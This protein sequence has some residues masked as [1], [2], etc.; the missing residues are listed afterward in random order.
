MFGV[1]LLERQVLGRQDAGL[2]GRGYGAAHQCQRHEAAWLVDIEL[3][4][5][6][7]AF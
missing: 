6:A 2:L 1:L 3:L 7:L 4:L 5:V